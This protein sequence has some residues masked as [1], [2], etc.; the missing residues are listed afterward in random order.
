MLVQDKKLF[1]FYNTETAPGFGVCGL[2]IVLGNRD[3]ELFKQFDQFLVY[4]FL[5]QSKSYLR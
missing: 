3:I 5:F 4:L 2:E 1:I